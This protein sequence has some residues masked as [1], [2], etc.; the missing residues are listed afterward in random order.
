[1]DH[2]TDRRA[3]NSEVAGKGFRQSGLTLVEVLITLVL[4]GM[5]AAVAFGG[6]RQI[7]EARIRL[8]PYLDLSQETTLVAGWF[9]VFGIR[10]CQRRHHT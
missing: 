7:F 4:L 3:P 9:L 2:V 8:R 6:L 10:R 5:V 1:M